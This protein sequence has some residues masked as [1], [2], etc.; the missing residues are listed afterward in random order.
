MTLTSRPTADFVN[1][2]IRDLSPL[3]DEIVVITTD[4][5]VSTSL[6]DTCFEKWCEEH[7]ESRRAR[8]RSTGVSPS[9]HPHLYADD[10]PETFYQGGPLD[11]EVYCGPFTGM[12]FIRD[13]AAVRSL[14]WSACTS[15]WRL[16]LTNREKIVNPELIATAC[17]LLASTNLESAL[18]TTSY[19]DGRR[20]LLCRLCRSYPRLT[21]EGV[22]FERVTSQS[23]AILDC[24]QITSDE[25]LDDS[26]TGRELWK[27][28]YADA[29]LKGWDIPARNLL[30]MAKTARHASMESFI[31]SLVS[32]HMRV[33]SCTPE[34]S[35]ACSI[36]A[37]HLDRVGQLRE[38]MRWHERAVIEHPGQKASLR[39]ACARLR[40]LDF[41]GCLASYETATRSAPTLLD[42]GPETA[43]KSLI[44]IVAALHELGRSSEAKECC[45]RL[46][47]LYPNHER[48]RRLQRVVEHATDLK[49]L[50]E[51]TP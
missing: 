25:R 11:G 38:A 44:L 1:Y 12:P 30:H 31:P 33:S 17:E 6:L 39:L 27:A 47:E 8:W 20:K 3:V 32:A 22:A 14:G 13:W 19:S 46:I 9:S 40:D 50:E 51:V 2:L 43:E 37:D 29:R 49:E 35:L 42:D 16:H 5:L 45:Q 7:P 23:P 15:E 18:T 34:R 26:V 4:N 24:L 10:I 41:A 28:L 48:L 36:M 21:F